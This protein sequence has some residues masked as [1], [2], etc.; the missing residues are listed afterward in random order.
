[1][2]T[3]DRYVNSG[4]VVIRITS[5]QREA[6][7]RVNTAARGGWQELF[8]RLQMGSKFYPEAGIYLSMTPDDA[9]RVLHYA[10]EY[11]NGGWQ[12]ALRSLAPLIREAFPAVTE[13]AQ[14]GLAL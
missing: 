10:Y 7:E 5:A 8:R 3:I 2:A 6:I 9:R 4:M 1:M 14:P 13:E 11:G 12:G